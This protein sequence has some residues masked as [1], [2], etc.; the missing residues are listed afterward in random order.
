[1]TIDERPPLRWTPQAVIGL[2]VAIV[3]VAL[4]A[5]NLGVMDAGRILG[6]WPLVVVVV[7]LT[8]FRRAA[9]DRARWWAGFVVVAGLWLTAGRVFGLPVRLSVL[10]P[11]GL[12][13]LGVMMVR[14]AS[15][16]VSGSGPAS[17][18]GDQA[19][20]DFA[21]WSG[22][23]RRVTSQLFRRADVTAVMGGIEMDFRPAAINGDAVIDVFVVMGGL[24]IRVPPDWTVSNQIVA[25]MGGAV[26]K[27]TGV[28][29]GRHRLVLRGFVLMGGVEVK[30]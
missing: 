5:E 4:T 12:V 30:T 25:V 20:S 6:L 10:F 13:A 8:M 16:L 17:A 22:V 24:E 7:G 9:D 28:P 26:D 3:G 11:I 21:F 27:S 23:E 19:I 1:M 29:D 14:R 2:C 15:G 18:G